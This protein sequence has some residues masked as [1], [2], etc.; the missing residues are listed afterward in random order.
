M[1]RRAL[2]GLFV[3]IGF[4]QQIDSNSITVAVSKDAALQ[5]DQVSFYVFINSDLT[6][7]LSDVL[8]ALQGTGITAENFTNV[9]TQADYSGGGTMQSSLYW[10]FS[11]TVP[12]SKLKDAS[13]ALGSAMQNLQ[14]QKSQLSLSFGV[15]GT[16]VS[17]SLLDSHSCSRSNLI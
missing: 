3:T 5:P 15:G 12:L 10:S 11:L 2:F 13:A 9:H 6:A 16:A 8:P 17:Q 4:G 1:F 7:S 14:R